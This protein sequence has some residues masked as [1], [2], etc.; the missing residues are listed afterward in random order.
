MIV[1]A[2]HLLTSNICELWQVPIS[3]VYGAND[4]FQS[5]PAT[6]VCENLRKLRDPL[7]G[8]DLQ[9]LTCKLF[10]F[11]QV[12]LMIRNECVD[13]CVCRCMFLATSG[14]SIHRRCGSIPQ[15]V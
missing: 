10:L 14:I 12:T 3:F 9:V 5:A 13:A 7:N 15:G 4:F 6:R 2:W 11:V 8:G 1:S